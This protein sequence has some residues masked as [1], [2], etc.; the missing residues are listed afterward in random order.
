MIARSA[1]ETRAPRRCRAHAALA[2][3]VA[4]L[5]ERLALERA[6]AVERL[7]ERD[8]EGELIGAR[9]D[10]AAG[11]LLG[12]HVRGRAEHGARRA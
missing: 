6:L 9:V 12:R 3:V 2:D 1:P 11:E 8:A 7:V 4:E 10:V 5:V